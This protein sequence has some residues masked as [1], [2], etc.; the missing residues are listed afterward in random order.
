MLPMNIG[1]SPSA[2][3]VC[4]ELKLV[5]SEV[6]LSPKMGNYREPERMEQGSVPWTSSLFPSSVLELPRPGN[7]VAIKAKD[8]ALEARLKGEKALGRC[9]IGRL[10]EVCSQEP[11]LPQKL[12]VLLLAMDAAIGTPTRE[13][14]GVKQLFLPQVGACNQGLR[15]R[16]P[17]SL[18]K[19][20]TRLRKPL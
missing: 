12:N 14:S 17:D 20:G 5:D 6:P 13:L 16:Q 2:R 8:G 9:W 1:N 18:R 7:I 10:D 15:R 3:F 11:E 19:L 4:H